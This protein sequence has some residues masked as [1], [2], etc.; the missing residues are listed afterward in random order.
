M[1]SHLIDHLLSV[2]PVGLVKNQSLRVLRLDHNS[3]TCPGI[4]TEILSRFGSISYY[5]HLEVKITI[6][7]LENLHNIK[8]C[9]DNMMHNLYLS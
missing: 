8:D 7:E 2:I 1:H 4:P 6:I 3:V 5:F 9:S